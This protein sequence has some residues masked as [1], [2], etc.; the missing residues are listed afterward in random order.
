[1][2]PAQSGGF[3]QVIIDREGTAAWLVFRK[4]VFRSTPGFTIFW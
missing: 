2:P 1:M 3:R 4:T